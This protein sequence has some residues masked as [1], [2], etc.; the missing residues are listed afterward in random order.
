MEK[1]ALSGGVWPTMITAFTEDGKLDFKANALLTDWLIKKGATGLFAVC[2]S[3]EMFFLTLQEKVDLAKC[4]V[5]ACNGRVPVVASGHTSESM[6]SQIEELARIS[7]T[8]VDAT[9]LVSN[10]LAQKE[11]DEDVLFK[12]INKVFSELSD[13]SLGIYECPFPFLRLLTIGELF[14]L[15]TSGRMTFVKDVSCNVDI[16][17]QRAD[18]FKETE[19]GLYNAQTETL[20]SSLKAGYAGYSGTM[21]NYHIDIYRW[22]YDNWDSGSAL[23]EEVQ[24][25]LSWAFTVHKGSYPISA[26]YHMNLEG[27]PFP[28]NT[29]SKKIEA[30]TPELKAAIDDLKVQET[31]MRKKLGI[32]N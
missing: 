32:A 25:W 4:I 12:N 14:R 30:F 15:S 31:A 20:L 7:E 18:C 1:K 13:V 21:G 16:Q 17:K 2:M 22:L 9:V 23:V 6:K 27:I 8:G 19:L 24:T 5:D 10:R 11:E 29:R 3:S 26:K 28:L